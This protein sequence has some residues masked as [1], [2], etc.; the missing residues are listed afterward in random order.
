MNDSPEKAARI[1]RPMLNIL[2]LT[3]GFIAVILAGT[4]L[5]YAQSVFIPLIIAWLLSLAL[6]PLVRLFQRWRIPSGILLS[7][8]LLL[9]MFLL[10]WIGMFI[11][12]SAATFARQIP[13]YQRTLG[14]ILSDVVEK[15]SYHFD[16]LS[17]EQINAEINQHLRRFAGQ[18]LDVISSL[19][20]LITGLISNIVMIIIILAFILAGQKYSALKIHNAFSSETAKRVATIS[21]SITT[22]LSYYIIMQTLISALTGLLV[23]L[24]CNL[25]GIDNAGT[26]GVLAFFLNFI[27][28]IGSIIAGIPPVLLALVQFYPNVWPAVIAAVCIIIINQV[29][30]NIVTPKV[31]GDRLDLSPVVILLSLLF[32]GWLWGIIGAFLSV[33]IAAS[34]K[35]VFEHIET[36]RPLAV[37]MS[38]GRNLP[39]PTK[40]TDENPA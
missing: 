8:V 3:V 20:G 13:E 16:E 37:F 34:L 5:K 15:I 7:L 28:T 36:L 32:W 19:A 33:I 10:Y 40:S 24:S 1:A 2:T 17:V 9:L 4:V 21:H 26:W 25:I 6:S 22:N 23:W 29:L 14:T 12:S 39:P 11:S 27:P 30:G 35:I 31:M 18:L 38:S